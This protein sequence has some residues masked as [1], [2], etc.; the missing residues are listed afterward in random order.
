M[1]DAMYII[2]NKKIVENTWQ[3]VG[4]NETLLP[5]GSAAQ[6]LPASRNLIVPLA[7]WLKDRTTLTQRTGKTGVW[8]KGSDDPAQLQWNGVPPDLP[9]I[10]VEFAQ[11]VDGRGY[12]IG[13]LLRERHG[14]KGE[15][16]AIGDVFRDQLPALTRCGFNSFAL[17]EGKSLGDALK[18]FDD[19]SDAYQN[20]VDQPAPY[21]RRRLATTA[22]TA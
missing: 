4:E 5:Q 14:F 19:F 9:L 17:K 13:R 22:T 20:A 12:S 8:L 10:A 6:A 16:R 21:Y 7:L 18:A 11:F 1:S 2:L 3:F 15:L